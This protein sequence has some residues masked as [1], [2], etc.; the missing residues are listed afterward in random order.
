MSMSEMF[1]AI[2]IAATG[3]NVDQ[4]WI[5]T[6]AGN[7]A[8]ADD[9]ATPG[10]PLYQEQEVEVAAQ[11]AQGGGPGDGVQVETVNVSTA[12]PTLEYDPSSPLA[13]KEGLVA[14]SNV[15]IGHELTSLV[16]AQVGY[17]ADSNV[18]QQSD[19]AYKAIL[20]ITS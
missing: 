2:G 19:D 3:V 12:P 1:P 8:N 5:D 4:T 14:V 13:N 16:E 10:K 11:P 17:E 20:G 6:I 9:E 15:N 7:V 18:L